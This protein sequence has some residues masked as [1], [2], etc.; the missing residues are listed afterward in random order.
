MSINSRK[1]NLTQVMSWM[2]VNNF[3]KEVKQ[4][5]N[6]NK[7]GKTFRKKNFK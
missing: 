1:S 7:G 3:M 2:K 5:P 6:R 4:K